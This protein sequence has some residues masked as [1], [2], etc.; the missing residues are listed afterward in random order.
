VSIG[1]DADG[2]S[3][4]RSRSRRPAGA[5]ALGSA[6]LAH[7]IAA[8]I[9]EEALQVDEHATATGHRR[10]LIARAMVAA[11]LCALGVVTWF[12]TL[13]L[14][15]RGHQSR[16]WVEALRVRQEAWRAQHAASVDR[17]GVLAEF[18]AARQR[19]NE[20]DLAFATT[21]M[22]DPANEPGTQLS[23][24]IAFPH[25]ALTVLARGSFT[26]EERAIVREHLPRLRAFV[27]ALR[28][29]GVIDGL[30]ANASLTDMPPAWGRASEDPASTRAGKAP[31]SVEYVGPPGLGLT[32]AAYHLADLAA[33]SA[34]EGDATSAL[35]AIDA[36]VRMARAL[37]YRGM[38][39]QG[40]SCTHA[41]IHGADHVLSSGL[42]TD[43][44]LAQLAA[45]FDSLDLVAAWDRAHT[46]ERMFVVSGLEAFHTRGG[47]VV[48]SAV[49]EQYDVSVLG[50]IGDVPRALNGLG[51][52]YPRL[53]TLT[54]H[55]D[56]QF[57][58]ARAY[59]RVT[60]P[61]ERAAMRAA[62]DNAEAEIDEL[63]PLYYQGLVRWWWTELDV[64]R[65]QLV[66]LRVA[67][68]AARYERRHGRPP[69]ALRDM[70]PEFF[71]AAPIDPSTGLP[72]D[73]HAPVLVPRP[74]E[75]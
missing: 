2:G 44:Q 16:D 66:R 63:E 74:L 9:A 59:A 38:S 61:A 67:I 20:I 51:L 3:W 73:L 53:G 43:E 19:G 52:A 69:D 30:I 37:S 62:F 6:R 1:R 15:A 22:D 7:R 40:L 10:R 41:A 26:D 11:A 14:T 49:S 25:G 23:E 21:W 50:V 56:Q 31:V 28:E 42:A 45:R 34:L 27:D 8:T 24:L 13:G 35:D 55:V 39:M 12:V 72:V 70:V 54:E 75:P 33:F 36:I 47:M 48:P 71:D 64:A 18:E 17:P 5:I 4:S 68:A 65:T 32:I 60:D 46:A 58:R 29:A 57:E